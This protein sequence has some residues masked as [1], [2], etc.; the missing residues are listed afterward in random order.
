MIIGVKVTISSFNILL[1]VEI[2]REICENFLIIRE[3]VKNSDIAYQILNGAAS[4]TQCI[5]VIIA[6]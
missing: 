3:K 1:Q 4:E 6:W 2:Y 5:A